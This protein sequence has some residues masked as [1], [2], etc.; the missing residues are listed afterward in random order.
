MIPP[1]CER[2]P[3]R[4]AHGNRERSTPR[5]DEPRGDSCAGPSEPISPARMIY[6]L[7]M[8]ATASASV[9]RIFAWTRLRFAWAVSAAFGLLIGLHNGPETFL[10]ADLLRA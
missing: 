2:R 8:A 3:L 1:T 4:R 7:P 6:S 5:A 9:P 10:L